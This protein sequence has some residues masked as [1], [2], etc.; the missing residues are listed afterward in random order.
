MR[1]EEIK[2]G[3]HVSFRES[4]RS[5]T[6]IVH[7]IAPGTISVLIDLEYRQ[8]FGHEDSRGVDTDMNH[9]WYWNVAPCN[10]NYI[11]P[12][13]ENKQFLLDFQA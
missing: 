1:L 4:G 8:H 7:A 9:R 3:Q 10:M 13:M 6:G 11:G 5:G 12:P 2:L